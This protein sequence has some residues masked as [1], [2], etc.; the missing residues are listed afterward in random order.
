MRNRLQSLG[1]RGDA[2]ILTAKQFAE[3]GGTSF[4]D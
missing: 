2:Q 4:L 3:R 1:W